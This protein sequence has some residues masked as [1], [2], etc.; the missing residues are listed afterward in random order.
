MPEERIPEPN[1]IA[2]IMYTSGTTGKPK[3]VMISNRNLLSGLS[4]QI[5]K[6]NG[7]R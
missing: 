1:S 7:I 3:G 2:V 6:I 5:E 4:G